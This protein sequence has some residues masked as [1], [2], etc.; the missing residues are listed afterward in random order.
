MDDYKKRH[1]AEDYGHNT[2]R[3]YDL[4]GHP[5]GEQPMDL[6]ERKRELKERFRGD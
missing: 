2:D 1:E 3:G 5:S 6:A 4:E